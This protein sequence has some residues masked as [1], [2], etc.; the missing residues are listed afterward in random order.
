V[1]RIEFY[2]TEAGTCPVEEIL[3][4]LNPKQSKKVLWVMQTVR[5]L[6][7]P[8]VQY[9][10]KLIG[11]DLW[12]IKTQLGSDAFRLIGFFDGE[13]LIILTCGFAK[14]HKKRRSKKSKQPSNE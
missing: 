8:P 11:T 4:Y 3:D 13:Q 10:K 6:P 9:F 7:K 1:R 14:I 5:R 2:R 12:E